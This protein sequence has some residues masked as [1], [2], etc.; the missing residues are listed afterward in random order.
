MTNTKCRVCKSP[1]LRNVWETRGHFLT[2]QLSPM[3][4]VSPLKWDFEVCACEHCGFMQIKKPL[5]QDL[6]YQNYLFPTSWKNHPHASALLHKLSAYVKSGNVLEIGCNDGAF[7]SQLMQCMDTRIAVG[8]EPSKDVYEMAKNRGLE[9]LSGFFDEKR[10]AEIKGIYGAF[11]LIY[12]R[13]VFEH[14]EDMESFLRGIRLLCDVDSV[15][16]IE[17]PNCASAIARGDM[18]FIWE[19]HI[20]YFTPPT[21][22]YMLLANGFKILESAHYL[23]SG[24]SMVYFCTPCEEIQ[25]LDIDFSQNVK[26]ALAFATKQSAFVNNLTLAL[27]G[28]KSLGGSILAYGGGGIV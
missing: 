27:E 12:T 11:N 5:S 26:D 22:E 4:L 10:A 23:F 2:K 16:M 1:N 7:L 18:S 13:H 19:E 24:E 3:P 17:V 8:I 28:I 15:V 14:I 9:V 20:N 6:L 25:N 21:L